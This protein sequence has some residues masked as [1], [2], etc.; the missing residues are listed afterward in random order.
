MIR[1]DFEF[2]STA[3]KAK[4]TGNEISIDFTG[5]KVAISKNFL[6]YVYGGC[7]I[8]LSVGIDYSFGNKEVSDPGSL[9]S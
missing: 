1:T 4:K 9:H 7:E 6:D 2:D 3:N 5:A 8:N